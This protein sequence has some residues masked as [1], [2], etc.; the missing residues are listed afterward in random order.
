MFDLRGFLGGLYKDRGSAGAGRQ[1]ESRAGQ[2]GLRRQSCFVVDDDEQSRRTIVATIEGLGAVSAEMASAGE[3]KTALERFV[4]KLIFMDISL[5]HSDAIEAIRWLSACQYAG[6]VQLVSGRDPQ[7]VAAVHAIGLKYHLKMLPPI[8]KPFSGSA[9][10]SIAKVQFDAREHD[11]AEDPTVDLDLAL[12]KGWIELWYQPKVDLRRLQ[13]AGLSASPRM[14]HPDYGIVLP[15][16]FMKR[17]SRQSTRRLAEFMMVSVMREWQQLR[18]IGPASKTA[19]NISVDAL[20][21]L[22]IAKMLREQ[23]SRQ[24]DWPGFTFELTEDHAVR[25]FDDVREVAAQLMIYGA[26]FSLDEFGA[27]YSSVTLLNEF[28]AS[29]IGL[30][31]T[32]AADCAKNEQRFSLCQSLVNLAHSANALVVGKAVEDQDALAALYKMGCDIAQGPVLC[33][34]MPLTELLAY[35]R[36]KAQTR[37][38]VKAGD[39][40]GLVVESLAS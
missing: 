27:G 19:I 2:R 36:T 9:I 25:S 26:S 6:A 40:A 24:A 32:I 21:K 11:A 17:A 20:T 15:A 1:I 34:A 8:A 14:R 30:S 13:L 33:R 29:E 35:L 39:S 16:E 12:K 5:Q 3:L 28:Q 10:R 23:Q 7:L 4:P 18:Q 22:D 38:R 31:T 37:R